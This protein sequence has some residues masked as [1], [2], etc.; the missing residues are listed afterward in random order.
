M[1]CMS[2]KR[3]QSFRRTDAA[4]FIRAPHRAIDIHVDALHRTFDRQRPGIRAAEMAMIEYGD[5]G[6]VFGMVGR[7]PQPRGE[8]S[9]RP[10]LRRDRPVRRFNSATVCGTLPDPLAMM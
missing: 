8:A 6:Q 9:W 10:F 4:K 1:R 2:G 7:L 3:S 5:G